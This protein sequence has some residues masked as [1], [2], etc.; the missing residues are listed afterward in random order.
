[1]VIIFVSYIPLAGLWASIFAD[2]IMSLLLYVCL[3]IIAVAVL[4]KIGPAEIWA[5]LTEVASTRPVLQHREHPRWNTLVN[6]T[7]S[8]G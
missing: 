6:G 5:G 1:M 2:T 7:A 8:T 3:I 4:V